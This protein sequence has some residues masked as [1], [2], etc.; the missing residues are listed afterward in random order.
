MNTPS[1]QATSIYL[2]FF[3][4]LHVVVAPSSRSVSSVDAAKIVRYLQHRLG[5]S[6][7]LT[8][9]KIQRGCGSGQKASSRMKLL[10]SAAWAA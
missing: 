2:P 1:E 7:L 4:Q 5:R 6:G 8:R 3:L 9:A 10:N